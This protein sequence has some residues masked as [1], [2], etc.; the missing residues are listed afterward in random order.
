MSTLSSA[1]PA[2]VPGPGSRP[3]QRAEQR[4][5]QRL[6][7]QG[8]RGL[9]ADPDVRLTST[10]AGRDKLIGDVIDNLNTVLATFSPARRPV[11]RRTGHPLPPGAG[12][13]RP[14]KR[15]R[16]R[17]GLHQ[18]R[19][20][21]GHRSA[22]RRPRAPQRDRDADRPGLRTDHGRPRLRPDDLVED[23]ADA[24][25]ILA[26][27]LY[28][29]YFRVLSL[30]RRDPQTQRQE[31]P[32][33]LRQGRRRG[34]RDGAVPGTPIKLLAERKL[35]EVVGAGGRDPIGA[36]AIASPPISYDGVHQ[37]MTVT[38][39]TSPPDAGGIKPAKATSGSGPERRPGPP[40]IWR[41][42]RCRWTSPVRDRTR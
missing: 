34:L 26:R 12:S 3:G 7:G 15:Y 41:A 35:A 36:R 27:G 4:T 25:Q 6:P 42:A 1:V 11:R 37:G 33:G 10:L 17:D 20:R 28:G 29:D 32:T 18:R 23:P 5:A 31:R 21:I 38:P 39:P 13:G 9:G 22:H 14:A 16:H 24:Y 40:S 30:V 2:I 19:G 8:H